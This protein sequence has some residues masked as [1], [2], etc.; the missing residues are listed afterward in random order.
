MPRKQRFKPSRKPKAV[1]TQTDFPKLEQAAPL[2]EPANM[3]EHPAMPDRAGPEERPPEDAARSA[4]DFGN[5]P[6]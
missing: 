3:Q 5:E 1:G 4:I 2:I 6:N